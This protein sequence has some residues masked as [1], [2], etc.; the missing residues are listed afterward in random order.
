MGIH[1]VNL[2]SQNA[3][4]QMTVTSRS[5]RTGMGNVVYV[6]GNGRDLSF[7]DILLKEKY[8]VVVD[9]MNY[10]TEEFH[11]RYRRLLSSCGQMVRKVVSIV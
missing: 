4:N 5:R 10:R 3:D 8:D 1:L 7:L 9:F 11:A 2:L 6:Q